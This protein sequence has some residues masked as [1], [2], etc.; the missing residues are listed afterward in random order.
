LKDLDS[1]KAG[2]PHP[3]PDATSPFSVVSGSGPA[4]LL[5]HGLFDSLETWTRL[6]PYLSGQYRVYA[7]DLPGFGKTPLPEVWPSSIS[8]MVD[9]VIQFLNQKGLDTV[10]I[11]GNSM[12]GGLSLAIAQKHPERIAR[13]VLLNPYGLPAVPI[14][15]EG[16]RRPIVGRLLPYLLSHAALKRCAKGIFSRSFYDPTFVTEA[17]IEQLTVPFVTLR[18][19]RNLF[20][21]LRSISTEEIVEIDRRL[22]EIQHSVLIIWGRN[23]AWLSSAHYTRLKARLSR[24]KLIT[25]AGCGHLPQIERPKEVSQSLI[26]FLVC[27]TDP[28]EDA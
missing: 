15:A 13:I 18:T 19:R 16:A 26:P 24:V 28:I 14:A 2:R 3:L 4:L 20:R 11:V 23:D 27:G 21:F 22:P 1:E 25:L 17:L 10:S 9:A 8:G 7:L 5:L 6:T 12:G